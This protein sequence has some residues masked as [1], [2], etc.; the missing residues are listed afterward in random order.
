MKKLLVFMGLMGFILLGCGSNDLGE[1]SDYG[2]DVNQLDG[3]SIELNEDTYQPEGD[4]FEL[5]VVNDSEEEITYGVEYSLEYLDE[6]V[7]F[8]VE[9]DEEIA[10]ILIAHILDSGDEATEEINLEYYEPLE[11]GRYRLVR[12][13]DGEPLTAE[14]EVVEE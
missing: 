13:V 11:I 14:F 7:W 9:P 1:E 4:Y 8:E 3:V 2:E 5:T 6:D 12:H 10:F